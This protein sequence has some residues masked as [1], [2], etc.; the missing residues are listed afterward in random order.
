MI[1]EIEP[2]SQQETSN[3]CKQSFNQKKTKLKK[4]EKINVGFMN[5]L[6]TKEHQKQG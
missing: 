4:K 2:E 6:T 1:P 5:N 3:R